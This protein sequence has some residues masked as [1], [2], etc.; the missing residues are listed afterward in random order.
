[1]FKFFTKRNIIVSIG[2]VAMIAIVAIVMNLINNTTDVVEGEA[3]NKP[4]VSKEIPLKNKEVKLKKED[5]IAKDKALNPDNEANLQSG[6]VF[7][8]EKQTTSIN[9]DASKSAKD[10]ERVASNT[11]I[12]VPSQNGR[13]VITVDKPSQQ[14]GNTPTSEKEVPS[15]SGEK[16]GKEPEKA[17]NKKPESNPQKE[18]ETEK[19]PNDK[20]TDKKPAK[21]EELFVESVVVE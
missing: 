20:D 1:M 10:E 9:G 6:S 19:T 2:L 16:P 4:S 18:P 7:P 21:A 12:T 11:P 15:P 8:E 14:Y 3:R 5:E 17:P 13:N